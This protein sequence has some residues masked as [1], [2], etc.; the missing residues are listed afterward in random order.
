MGRPALSAEQLAAWYRSKKIVGATPTVTV[1]VLARL[2]IEEGFRAGVAGDI[3]F[4]Q[5]M[6][7]TGWLRFSARVPGSYNNFAGIGAYDG[8]TGAASFATAQLG[9]RA[10]IQL[11]RAYADP[12][13]TEATLGAPPVATNWK[14]IANWVDGK[15]PL[16][17]NFGNG[18]WATSPDYAPL[19]D[20]L[21][22]DAAA[23]AGVTVK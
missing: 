12:Y 3:A 14:S 2:Y 17:S 16:W 10:H 13:V 6:V 18:T 4:A 21:Y 23:H 9:V 11:L 5:A 7:E 19:L 1:D 20:K 22:R 8:G 15:A